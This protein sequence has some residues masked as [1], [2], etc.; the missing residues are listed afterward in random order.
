MSAAEGV[1]LVVAIAL[2]AYLTWALLRG[3]NL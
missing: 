2:F 3:E 1:L